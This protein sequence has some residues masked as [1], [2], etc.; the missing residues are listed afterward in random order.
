M[1]GDEPDNRCSYIQYDAPVRS[2]LRDGPPVRV[3]ANRFAPRRGPLDWLLGPRADPPCT[4]LRDLDRCTRWQ[5]VLVAVVYP[6]FF[7]GL[8]WLNTVLAADRE[9]QEIHQ[10]DLVERPQEGSP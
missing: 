10:R 9:Q 6:L 5:L 8:P 7:I 2:V 4:R 3:S 1:T